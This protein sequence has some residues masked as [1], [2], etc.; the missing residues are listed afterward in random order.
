MARSSVLSLQALDAVPSGIES[1]GT[2]TFFF[3][4][5][6]GDSSTVGPACAGARAAAERSAMVGIGGGGALDATLQRAAFLSFLPPLA[7]LSFLCLFRIVTS[8][9]DPL[10]CPRQSCQS[11]PPC[12]VFHGICAIQATRRNP[13]NPCTCTHARCSWPL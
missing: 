8:T 2:S 3:W 6:D 9:V 12:H 4:V 5:C 7:P 11:C 13:C 1:R 10:V